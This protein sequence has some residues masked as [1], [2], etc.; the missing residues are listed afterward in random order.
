MAASYTIET[1][2][3]ELQLTIMR[4]VRS[5]KSLLSLL[6]ASPRF[7]QVFRSRR[8]SV[9]SDLARNQFHEGIFANAWDTAKALQLPQPITQEI[10]AKF[11]TAF[12]RDDQH[13][14]P[15]LPLEMSISICQLG[16]L[17]DWFCHDFWSDCLG[18]LKQLGICLGLR[19]DIQVLES[20]PSA[21]EKGRVQRAFCR[22]ETM[23]ILL[24][25]LK[26]TDDKIDFLIQG[27]R[28]LAQYAEDDVEELACV[29][30]YF[31]RRLWGVI[32][33][34]EED[35]MRAKP[36]DAIRRLGQAFGD[37]DWFGR[38]P[39]IFQLDYIENMMTLGL[40]FLRQVLQS[41]GLQRAGLV[42][43]ASRQTPRRFSIPLSNKHFE[44]QQHPPLYDSCPT[45]GEQE[46]SGDDLDDCSQG[47]VFANRG[48]VILDYNMGSRKG[49]RDWGYVMLDSQRLK[50]AGV[51]ER[52]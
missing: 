41:Q 45:Y 19:Q 4:H 14:Q 36:S 1:L 51:L 2:Q 5:T 12:T 7:Y 50:A 23:G 49:L 39:K 16:P 32:E 20:P 9:L 43:A 40:P 21:I 30:D 46:F 35:G 10:S 18:N 38:V 44:A 42:M 8:E 52:E 33:A 11:I 27:Q 29:R 13:Q 6:K 15:I 3:P 22:F 24:A 25:A 17:I 26:G 48:K 31:V 47:W 28:F 37:H 34:I